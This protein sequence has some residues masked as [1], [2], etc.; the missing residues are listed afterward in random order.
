MAKVIIET[1][2]KHV[3]LSEKDLTVLFGEGAKLTEKRPLSQPGQFLCEERVVLKGEKGEIKNVAILGP[4]RPDTQ[5][6]LSFTDARALG[7]VPPIRES[8]DVEGSEKCTIVGPCGSVDIPYGVIV[9]KRHIHFTPEDA[10][11]FGVK[12][13]DIVTVKTQG[14]RGLSFDNTVVRVSEKFQTRMHIDYDEA[15]SAGISGE[16]EGEVIK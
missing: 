4:T 12:D 15:N 2:A 8:G 6:E 10:E 11:K 1:S 7:V 14:E 13:K 9:A 16:V 5:V 3:H